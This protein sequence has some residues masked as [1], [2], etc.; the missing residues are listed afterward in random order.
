MKSAA[1]LCCVLS[2]LLR[3][4]AAP[5]AADAQAKSMSLRASDTNVIVSKKESKDK[6]SK[7][8]ESKATT[9]SQSDRTKEEDEHVRQETE[10]FLRVMHQN[11][12]AELDFHS[13]MPICITHSKKVCNRVDMGYTD[14]QLQTALEH[15]CLLEKDFPLVYST[16]FNKWKKK[17]HKSDFLQVLMAR[18]TKGVDED[19]EDDDD[20]DTP[21]RK[22]LK[23]C[24]KFAVLLKDARYE[25]LD[26][27]DHST[28]GYTSF[29]EAY[30]EYWY[31]KTKKEK[32]VIEEVIEEEVK[33]EEEVLEEVVPGETGGRLIQWVVLVGILL[34][35]CAC[36][37]CYVAH[38]K[39]EDTA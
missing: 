22:T 27:P 20:D 14:V 18:M 8:K 15:Q 17:F 38:K 1:V 26:T 5:V 19:D 23:A 37:G 39:K 34:A 25:E 11:V 9:K 7:E 32:D 13:F 6:E 12:T 21:Q 3:A 35:M 36:L 16:G 2:S 33:E 28:K 31:G 4:N 30:Y 10:D 29:C 24:R